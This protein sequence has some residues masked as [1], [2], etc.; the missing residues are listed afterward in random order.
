MGSATEREPREIIV[1][2]YGNICRSPIGEVLLQRALDAR[3]GAGVVYVTSAGIGADDGRPASQGTLKALY[4][5]GID[6]RNHR[7]RYLTRAMAEHAWRI[8]CMEEYQ[9]ARARE[10]TDARKVMLMGEEVPDPMGSTQAAYDAVAEQL[11]RLLP[12]VVEDIARALEAEANAE[13]G[14]V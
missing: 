2:C 7:S 6:F 11:E 1:V 12:A 13:A 14:T 8:Y 10:L 5:R 9:C 4:A 3:L